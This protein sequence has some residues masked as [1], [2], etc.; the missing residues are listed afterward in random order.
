MQSPPQTDPIFQSSYKMRLVDLPEW[1][2]ILTNASETLEK[3]LCKQALS[4]S[5][6]ILIWTQPHPDA[7]PLHFLHLWEFNKFTHLNS[8]P[9]SLFL[10]CFNSCKWGFSKI[11]TIPKRL[12]FSLPAMMRSFLS[13]S[14]ENKLYRTTAK[15]TRLVGLV[16]NAPRFINSTSFCRL[17]WSGLAWRSENLITKTSHRQH[18]PFSGRIQ[19]KV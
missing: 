14:L 16:S 15:W 2:E 18:Q 11:K 1:T 9:D 5:W 17:S 13:S 12:V 19:V 4:L 7:V 8:R 10:K 3:K 6:W